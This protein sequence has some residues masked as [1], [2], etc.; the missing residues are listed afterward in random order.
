MPIDPDVAVGADLGKTEF[1]WTS[2]DVLLYHLGIGFGSRPGDNLDPRTLSFTTENDLQVAPIALALT[3]GERAAEE[4]DDGVGPGGQVLRETLEPQIPADAD[5]ARSEHLP[6][7]VADVR[8]VFDLN[9]G[10][11]LAGARER[12]GDP[13]DVAAEFPGDVDAVGLT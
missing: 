8:D 12:R 9:G 2:T 6:V 1:A 5:R 3:F 7:L 4:E 10:L 13:A 11:V